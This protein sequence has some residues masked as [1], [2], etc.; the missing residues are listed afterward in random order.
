MAGIFFTLFYGIMAVILGVLISGSFKKFS[1]NQ[2]FAKSFAPVLVALPVLAIIGSVGWFIR[3]EHLKEAKRSFEAKNTRWGLMDKTGKYTIAPTYLW[4]LEEVNAQ[5]ITFATVYEQT[6]S[7]YDTLV[8]EATGKSLPKQKFEKIPAVWEAKV[9]ERAMSFFKNVYNEIGTIR[10]ERYAGEGFVEC[11]YTA[12]GKKNDSRYKYYFYVDTLGIQVIDNKSKGVRGGWRIGSPF[13]NGFALVYD[14]DTNFAFIDTNGKYRA[15][16]DKATPF[17]SGYAS[18]FTYKNGWQIIDTT[19]KVVAILGEKYSEVEQ[20][21]EGKAAFVLGEKPLFFGEDNTLMGVLD[22]A[23][24]KEIIAPKFKQIKPFSEGLAAAQDAQTL[25]WGYIDASG[26]WVLHAKWVQ[27]ESFKNG[28]A[29]TAIALPDER[30]GLSKT[31]GI[32]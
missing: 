30:S 26:N 1:Q 29:T 24:G 12:R 8:F 28:Y 9:S 11:W 7:S 4:P 16:Y 2:G 17:G 23:T 13:S 19:F 25:L 22:A 3:S 27:A 31:L 15:N 18:V 14:T 5:G 6:E 21:A 32:Y 10:V 20:V